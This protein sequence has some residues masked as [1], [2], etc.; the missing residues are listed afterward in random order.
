MQGLALIEL[1]LA[2]PFGPVAI[3]RGLP[4]VGPRFVFGR[5]SLADP[6]RTHAW[7]AKAAEH[8]PHGFAI[9]AVGS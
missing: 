3:F 1:A 6:L 9:A 5:K 8:V 7:I 4:L 2:V